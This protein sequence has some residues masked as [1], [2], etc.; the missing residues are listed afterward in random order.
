MT[1][2]PI[3]FVLGGRGGL[4]RRDRG[5]LRTW[6][7]LAAVAALVVIPLRGLYRFT[8][9]TMEEGFMLYFPERIAAGDVPNVDFL[10]LYG[11]G[12]LHVLR[13]WYDVFGHSLAVERTFGL[14]QHLG[15]VFAL[16]T[17]ARAWGRAAATAVAAFAVFYVLTP[18]GLTAMAWNGALALILWSAVFAVRSTFVAGRAQL[19]ARVAAGVLG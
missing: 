12:S 2:D 18:I 3:A 7:G 10:H 15:I 5:A 6:A 11:P 17:L 4:W 19:L 14:I 8:G 16:F 13:W 9:G 1:A